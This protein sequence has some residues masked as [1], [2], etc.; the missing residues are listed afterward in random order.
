MILA[1]ADAGGEFPRVKRLKADEGID[2]PL[3]DALGRR[4]RH[5]FDVDAAGD[6][7]DRHHLPGLSVQSEGEVVLGLDL[8]GVP[9]QHPPGP[10][11]G[12]IRTEVAAVPAQLLNG[13]Y[14]PLWVTWRRTRSSPRTSLGATLNVPLI[15]SRGAR[16]TQPGFT[17]ANRSLRNR[18][19]PLASK[20][21]V[22]RPGFS[23]TGAVPVLG[24]VSDRSR[25][26]RARCT[27]A[28]CS[29]GGVRRTACTSPRNVRREAGE[30]PQRGA[31]A[32]KAISRSPGRQ[33]VAHET[34]GKAACA[35][36]WACGETVASTTAAA[37]STHG[38]FFIG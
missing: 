6:R 10:L 22:S 1:Q 13:K 38:I 28:P 20:L 21:T 18:R 35:A 27:T 36:A 3:D 37:S 4:A 26:G 5:L 29:R 30:R 8:G 2:V 16:L 31:D 14:A 23:H 19:I 9:N 32:K 11:Y 24:S 7:G 12:P 25:L 34:A 33:A 17:P 15:P